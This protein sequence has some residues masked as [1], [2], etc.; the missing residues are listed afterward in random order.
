MP[1]SRDWPTGPGGAS[2]LPG[3]AGLPPPR[4]PLIEAISRP[5][6]VRP[7]RTASCHPYAD[8]KD[9]VSPHPSVAG[10]G[11]E[12]PRGDLARGCRVGRG[13]SGGPLSCALEAGRAG[14][15]RGGAWASCQSEGA[16][17]EPCTCSGERDTARVWALLSQLRKFLK[18]LTS[19]CSFQALLPI[20]W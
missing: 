4:R 9:A 20:H 5:A 16:S 12:Q 17:S 2:A 13:E 14:Q 8:F 18:N 7:S 11:R 1:A 15:G 19:S 3:W 6:A 10:S